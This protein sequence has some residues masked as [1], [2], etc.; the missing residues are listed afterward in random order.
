MGNFII[1]NECEGLWYIGKKAIITSTT[2]DQWFLEIIIVTMNI[3]NYI[4][5][6]ISNIGTGVSG[7][8]IK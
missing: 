2:T 1:K 8:I 4:I 7:I 3:K 6:I 5:N